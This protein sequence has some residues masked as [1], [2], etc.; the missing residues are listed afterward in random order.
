MHGWPNFTDGYARGA[1]ADFD[2]DGDIE[3]AYS[4]NDA[5]VLVFDNVGQSSFQLYF[6]TAGDPNGQ[7]D[8]IAPAVDLDGDHDLDL[9]VWSGRKIGWLE[10]VPSAPA[11]KMT[12]DQP[13]GDQTLRISLDGGAPFERFFFVSTQDPRNEL[14]LGSGNFHGLFIPQRELQ[15]K[16][17]SKSGIFRGRLDENGEFSRAHPYLPWGLPH[18]IPIYGVAVH[19][20]ANGP[21]T[22]SSQP[23]RY[24]IQ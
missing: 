3:F 5:E 4:R 9:V 14:G 10:N 22:A 13:G 2:G 16:F 12:V 17:H 1:S 15:W 11:F 21:I 20:P 24:V 19:F 23:I 18:G 7:Y 6:R 8:R